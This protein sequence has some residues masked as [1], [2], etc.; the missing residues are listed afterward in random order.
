VQIDKNANLLVNLLDQA[1]IH[2][3]TARD[4]P[5]SAAGIPSGV[6]NYPDGE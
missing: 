1:A 6:A 2:P 3:L 4:P 5:I